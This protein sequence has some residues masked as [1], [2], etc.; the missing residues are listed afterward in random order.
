MKSEN[1][2]IG[3]AMIPSKKML[4]GPNKVVNEPHKVFF[5]AETIVKI[6]EKFHQ[7]NFDNRVNINHDGVQVKGVELTQS[8]ILSEENRNDLD[9]EFR[10]LPAGTWMVEYRID[11]EDIWQQIKDK[12]LNGFS[13]E[14]IFNYEL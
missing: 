4:R 11:N 1:F 6:R 3:P 9:S 10:E 5:T 8:F 13:V 2:I 14:G 12:K 7:N